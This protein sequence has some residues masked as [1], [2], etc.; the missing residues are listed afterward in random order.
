MY[1]EVVQVASTL[2]PPACHAPTLC[3][4]P[5]GGLLLAW[6]AGSY[7]GAADTVLACARRTVSGEWAASQLVLDL[8]GLPVGNPVLWCEGEVVTL[9]FVI[10]YGSWWTDA[11]LASMCSYDGGATWSSPHLLRTENG[12]MSRSAP[13][14][15]RTGTLLLP[16]YDERTWTPLILRQETGAAWELVGDTTARGKAIQP[17][18][19]LLPDDSVLMLSR[20]NQ[21]SVFQSWSFNDGRSW[22]ASQPT[23][24]PNPNSSIALTCL[25][26]GGLLLVYNPDTTGRERL[27]VA[28]SDDYGR[29]WCAPTLLAKGRGEYSYPYMIISR[30]G[31]QVH[32]VF[33]EHR[34]R[35]RYVPLDATWLRRLP[36]ASPDIG[37]DSDSSQDS[38]RD[39]QLT[40]FHPV[41]DPPHGG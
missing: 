11:K 26:D 9:F 2:L 34:I 21:G 25:P 41:D 31:A 15:L 16:I 32:L 8:A 4:L 19:A 23:S 14:R 28:R 18:L 7:E 24:L 3:E 40:S 27:A 30:S 1:D 29:N 10:V 17:A 37:A 38:T 36:H 5:D 22:T 39:A 20:T 33:T 35:F 13:I 6:Y 12:L